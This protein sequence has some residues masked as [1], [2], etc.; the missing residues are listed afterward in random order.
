MSTYIP[1]CLGKYDFDNIAHFA[2]KRFFQGYNTIE[3]LQEAGSLQEKEEIALVAS[4]D[5]DDETVRDLHLSCKYAEEC[6]VTTCR[7]FIKEMIHRLKT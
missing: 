4:I 1:N 7:N 2:K 3:L 6:H 5:L